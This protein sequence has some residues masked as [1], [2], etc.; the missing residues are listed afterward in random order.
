MARSRPLASASAWIFVLRPPRERPTACFYS[1][2]SARSRTMCFDVRRVDHLCGSRAAAPSKLPEQIF[3]NATPRPAHKAI[4]DRCRRTIFGRAITPATA[5][6]Q[7]MHN[8]ADDAAIIRPFDAPYIRRQ[9]R[10]DPL[11]L[12]IAQP[13]FLRTDQ[14]PERRITSYGIR[15]VLAAAP[16]A[17]RCGQADADVELRARVCNWLPLRL[18]RLRRERESAV[19]VT[20]ASCRGRRAP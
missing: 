6:F 1:P 13:R 8:A 17:R 12:L 3:P 16:R 11:P 14:S 19:V 18:A 15:I 7:H 9:M 20:G 5:A 4:I 10:F 2:F